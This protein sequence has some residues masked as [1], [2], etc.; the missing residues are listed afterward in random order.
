MALPLQSGRF[1]I[2]GAAPQAAR[3]P[4][5][6]CTE[7]CMCMCAYCMYCLYDIYS[8]PFRYLVF[9]SIAAIHSRTVN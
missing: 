5:G 9:P 1:E 6:L 2:G 8:G 4:T 3:T 7:C